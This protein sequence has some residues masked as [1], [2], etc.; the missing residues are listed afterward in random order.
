MFLVLKGVNTNENLNQMIMKCETFC[1]AEISDQ[2]F[3]RGKAKL[4]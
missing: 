3:W 4:N 1:L 2:Y